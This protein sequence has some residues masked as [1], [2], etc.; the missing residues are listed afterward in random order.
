[1]SGLI[2]MSRLGSMGRFG[3]QV[4]EYMF[5]R[6]YAQRYGLDY[7]VSPWI[8]QA[9]FGHQDPPLIT[10]LPRYDERR[11]RIGGVSRTE[12]LN[13]ALSQSMPPDSMEVA[14][15]D[16]HGYAQFHTSYYRPQREF[17]CSLFVSIDEL[18]QRLEPAVTPLTDS[19]RTTIGLHMR[20]G[21]TGRLIFYLTPNEWYLAWLKEHWSRFENPQLFIASEEPSDIEAFRE[22]H[23][24][25]AKNLIQLSDERYQLYNYLQYDLTNP[26]AESMDW[27]PDWW[28]LTHCDVLLFGE[29]TFSFSAAMMDSHLRECWR[30]VLSKQQFVKI[31]PWDSYPLV[32]EHL[33]DYPNIP[34][35]FYQSNP[36]WRGGEVVPQRP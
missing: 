34:G 5:I 11:I 9:L 36:K 33:D 13:V 28:L 10:N 31:D 8:G 19:R 4:F 2:T 3:N 25:S 30:S 27:F 15:H 14:G 7:Q 16:F 26:T 24:I 22:Y 20:R 17:I 18:R 35:T 21:D 6:S 23:P 32:R 29:S 12:Q 1:M